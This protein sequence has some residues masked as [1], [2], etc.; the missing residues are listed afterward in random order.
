MNNIINYINQCYGFLSNIYDS[1]NVGLVIMKFILGASNVLDFHIMCHMSCL[2]M[3]TI[4]IKK[5]LKIYFQLLCSTIGM[6]EMCIEL[7]QLVKIKQM[8]KFATCTKYVLADYVRS[9]DTFG[10]G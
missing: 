3:I 4:L 7:S 10:L 1:W 8:K 9:R 2:I 5:C 6:A